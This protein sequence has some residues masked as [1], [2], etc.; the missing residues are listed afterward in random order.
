M[1]III[2]IFGWINIYA[3]SY[4]K[5]VTTALFSLSS[6]PGR[7]FLW[8]GGAGMLFVISLFF[9]T[10]FYRSLAYT[11]YALSLMLLVGTLIWGVKVGGHS[12]WLQWGRIQVQPTEFV[13]LTCT[14]ALAK[15]LDK[16][17]AKLTQ[18]KTQVTVLYIILIPVILILLQKDVGSALVF[19]VFVIVLYRE[20]LPAVM[21]TLGMGIVGIL[22][23]NLLIPSTYLIIA[24]LGI[25]LMV[26]G[27]GKKSIK[28]IL[29]VSA[30]TFGSICLIEGFDWI[31]KHAL[32]SHQQNRLKVLVNPGTDPLGIGW[33][34]TQ[35]K[36]AIGSGGLWG[37]GFLNGTQTKY[38][39]VPEQRK[40]F[41]FCT[42][43]EEYGWVGTLLFITV[44]MGLVLRILYLAERQRIR[45]AR[46][47]GY[48][49]ASVLFFHFFVNIG[50][51][52]GL[53]P[54]IGIPLPFISYGGS[55]L[56]SFSMML[57]ILLKF[58]SERNQYVSWKTMAV[59]LD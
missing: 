53:L 46:V 23:L 40:D 27:S 1:Y 4:E 58:D 21:F 39:F 38:G 34:L 36:I 7:Q 19:S 3:V 18:L 11:F 56:W 14:L 55:S 30:L 9:D 17:T 6:S 48:G 52:I 12:S 37:K 59:D 33:N 49:V 43:G 44:F 25:G 24:A 5:G 54:V 10:Q 29:M 16:V 42:I 57:F 15:R 51:T 45:F 26:V 2:V 35:S 22:V 41:I 50:M 13:K 8:I 31:V 32:K 28:R 20:G 47:Y